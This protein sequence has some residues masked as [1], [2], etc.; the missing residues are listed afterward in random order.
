MWGIDGSEGELETWSLSDVWIA[1]GMKNG[2]ETFQVQVYD[3]YDWS[4]WAAIDVATGRLNNQKS[5][6][7]AS[8]GGALSVD[9]DLG[10]VKTAAQVFEI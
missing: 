6:I 2:R 4:D 9:S 10:M 1:G 8:D 7:K 5:V 3:G